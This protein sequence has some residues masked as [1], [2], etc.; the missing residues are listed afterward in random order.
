MQRI[1]GL[2][3]ALGH[4]KS[5]D[6][7]KYEYPGQ[8]EDRLIAGQ[9]DQPLVILGALGN[10]KGMREDDRNRGEQA[11]RVEI[12]VSRPRCVQRRSSRATRSRCQLA[13]PKAASAALARLK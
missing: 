4:Q 1:G 6:R 9:Q 10:Q 12:I 2:L 3:K 7:K 11:Q 8:A 13:S 5:A